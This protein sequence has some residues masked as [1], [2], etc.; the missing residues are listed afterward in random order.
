VKR[1]AFLKLISVF[2]IVTFLFSGCNL[3][4]LNIKRSLHKNNFNKTDQLKR[5]LNNMN[6][7]ERKRWYI[8]TYSDFAIQQMKK[9]KIPASIILSQ[10]LL[11]SGAG[12]STLALKSNNH[13]GIKCHQ[14]WRGKKVYHDDDEKGECFRKYKNPIE[15]YKDHSEFLTTRG[16]YSFLFRYSIKDYIKWSEGLSKAGYATDPNYPEK[17]I[18]IIEDYKLWK[19]DGSKKSIDKKKRRK[20][21]KEKDN[22]TI[23]SVKKGDT[24]YS[25][26]KKYNI[27]IEKLKKLNDLNSINLN[28]GQKLKVQH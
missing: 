25:I 17:L 21:A 13:F 16:R 26:S 11:E 7:D 14:E 20:P 1:L 10:G 28:I 6:S 22:S 5:F 24:L 4:R 9:Y 3:T 18:S 8:K 27:S 15:S 23:H 12:V 19:F 2:I